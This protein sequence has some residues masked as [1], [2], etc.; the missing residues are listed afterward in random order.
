MRRVVELH[1]GTA[2][3]TTCDTD[4]QSV[5]E[6]C[7]CSPKQVIDWTVLEKDIKRYASKSRFLKLRND[8]KERNK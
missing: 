7:K 1:D 5:S 3:C 2:I 6:A 8:S 4:L